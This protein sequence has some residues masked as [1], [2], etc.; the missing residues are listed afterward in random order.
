MQNVQKIIMKKLPDYSKNQKLLAN[1]ILENLQTIPLLSVNELANKSGVSSATVVRFSRVLGYQGYLE[2]RN[3]LMDLLKESLS[4]ADKFK[5]TIS[6]KEEYH[7]SL[8]KIAQQV[9]QNINLSLQQNNLQDFKHI[10]SHLREAEN[11]HCIGLGISKYLAEIMAYQLK[12]YLKKSYAM[13]GDSLSFPEQIVL[14]TPRDLIIAF[15]FPPYSRQTVE[16]A[17]LAHQR[18]IPV[19]SFTDKK[20]APIVQ[21]SLHVLIAK[22]D[23]ILFTNSLGAISMLIN[24]LITEIVLTEEK[25]VLKGLQTIDKYVNDPRYF[26]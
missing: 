20:T 10:V 3:H 23:N 25:K 26:Y 1:Y 22:T 2:F 14:L 17:Q 8:H 6:K 7:D 5:A 24:A 4:P 13:S 9:V 21:Y 18:K 19:V 16:A 15:S 12:L 11:I